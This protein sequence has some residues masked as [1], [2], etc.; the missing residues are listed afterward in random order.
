MVCR[1]TGVRK[2]IA[3]TVGPRVTETA[4][5]LLLPK[6]EKNGGCGLEERDASLDWRGVCVP[7]PVGLS[8]YVSPSLVSSL[9]QVYYAA[10]VYS[11]ND[12][13]ILTRPVAKEFSWALDG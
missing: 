2:R 4:E 6:K 3:L 13:T 8:I 5:F 9:D 12:N 7:G 1:L 11:A 10:G